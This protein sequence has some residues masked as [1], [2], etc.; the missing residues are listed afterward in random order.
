M[1]AQLDLVEGDEIV[2]VRRR[3][4]TVVDPETKAKEDKI[5]ET[6]LSVVRVPQKLTITGGGS[7]QPEYLADDENA[8]RDRQYLVARWPCRL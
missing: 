3:R 7:L 8:T 1:M 5:E 6:E 4:L 2:L